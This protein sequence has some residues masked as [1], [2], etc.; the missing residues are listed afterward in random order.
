VIDARTSKV[1]A[2]ISLGGEPEFAAVDSASDRVYVN[3]E[4]KSEVAAIDTAKH[5]VVAHWPLAPGE[6][7]SGIALDAA[8]H[9]L[10]STCHNKMMTM[11]D[12]QSGK[13]VGTA[14]I[15]TGVDGAAFDDSTQLAFASCGEGVTT[16]LKEETPEKLSVIQTLKTERSARTMALDPKT[17]RIY[18][19]SAQ[20][21][22]ASS[23]SPGSSPA[24]PK[25]VPNTLKLLIYGPIGT[26][27]P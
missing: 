10:F 14:P 19:P 20:F 21:E 6:E 7:P 17:H 22:P 23:P 2:T 1:A 3:I 26:S 9:R 16:I 5:E 8:H 4:D 13:V 18:L 12:T 11:L 24:R 15:G 25:I 27:K